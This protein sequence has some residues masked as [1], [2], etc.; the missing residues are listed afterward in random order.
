V[1]EWLIL[2][3]RIREVLGSNF[4]PETACP[5]RGVLWFSSVPPGKCRDVALNTR[6][7]PHP[8]KSFTIHHLL[9]NLLFDAL[10][11]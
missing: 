10:Y 3:L 8:S 2:L 4:G 1:V 7:L 5:D 9:I 11:F 6:S